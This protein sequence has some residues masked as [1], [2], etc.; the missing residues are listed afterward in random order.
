VACVAKPAKFK[1]IASYYWCDFLFAVCHVIQEAVSMVCLLGWAWCS[2]FCGSWH[3]L[4]YVSF[5]FG[6]SA[7]C[8]DYNSSVVLAYFHTCGN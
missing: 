2:V 5:I 3:W 8:V 7:K 6:K 4:A 1:R